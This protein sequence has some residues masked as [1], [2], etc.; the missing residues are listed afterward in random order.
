MDMKCGSE[1][2]TMPIEIQLPAEQLQR[3]HLQIH[4][5]LIYVYGD[6]NSSYYALTPAQWGI[7]RI[8]VRT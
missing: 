2:S 7:T 5:T 4:I 3:R 6:A 1:L 8:V